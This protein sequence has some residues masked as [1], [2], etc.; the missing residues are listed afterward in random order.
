MDLPNPV[1]AKVTERVIARSQKTR[2]AYLHVLNMPKANSQ[3]VVH[4][5]VP[6]WLMV[7]LAWKI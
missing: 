5:H 7:L 4:S 6:T 1:L 3:L 2:S